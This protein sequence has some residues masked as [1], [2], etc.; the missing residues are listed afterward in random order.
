M[1]ARTVATGREVIINGKRHLGGE[2]VNL[3]ETTALQLEKV[4]AVVIEKPAQRQASRSDEVEA[5]R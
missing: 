4:G 3:D 1:I 5:A 2:L